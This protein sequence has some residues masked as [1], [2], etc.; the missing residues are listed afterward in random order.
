MDICD[1]SSQYEETY[2]NSALKQS[3]NDLEA[4]IQPTHTCLYCG[5]PIKIPGSKFCCKEC[6][7]EYEHELKVKQI[8]GRAY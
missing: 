5:D 6:R 3:K 1:I 8:S 7:D 2:L 4:Y